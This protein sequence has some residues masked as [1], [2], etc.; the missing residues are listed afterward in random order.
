MRNASLA[1]AIAMALQLPS[2]WAQDTE[3]RSGKSSSPPS[4]AARTSM[5]C[6]LA[7]TPIRAEKLDA[8]RPAAKTCAA[9]SGRV[10]GLNIESSY[11]RAFPRFYIR[12]LGN[13]DFDLDASQPVS[14]IVDDVVRKSR[15]EGLA[16][17]R[18][19]AGRSAARPARHAV[20]PQHDRRHR[21]VRLRQPSQATRALRQ[22][23]RHANSAT[24]R[25]GQLGDRPRQVH[26]R[27]R[28]STSAATTGWTTPSPTGTTHSGA[29]TTRRGRVQLLYDAGRGTSACSST[30][31]PETSTARRESS[32]PTSSSPGSN[33]L[34]AGFDETADLQRR[35]ERRTSTQRR[36]PGAA[37][38]L[39]ALE[40]NSITGYE[41][42]E[43][44]YSRGDIDGGFGAVFPPPSARASSR[45]RPKPPTACPSISSGRRSSASSPT[46]RGRSVG[47]AASTTSTRRLPGRELQ[48]R[49]LGR[50]R[51]ERQ[52][53]GRQQDNTAWR[54]IRLGRL[55]SSATQFTLSAGLRYTK[56][57]KDFTAERFTSPVGAGPIGPIAVNTDED[58]VSWDVERH[59]G[60]QR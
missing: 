53:R 46:P 54:G 37:P 21:E 57:E 17:V 45:S 52:R 25:R 7:V 13:T 29:T 43:G 23:P 44:R 40:L 36:Q 16:D 32:A 11:G 33:D 14:V 26:A 28:C 15:A 55:A 27:S 19:R 39:A 56:D 18:R 2:A 5:T 47:R 6:P 9:L 42:V 50:R 60:G 49:H 8:V 41:H 4:A 59:L 34:V 38:G 30:S 10:P 35:Q 48:L 24:R 3:R 31:T 58:H 12:G 51:G 1:A 22:P 20:W